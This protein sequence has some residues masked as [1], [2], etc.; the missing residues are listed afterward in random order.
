[1][2]LY[3]KIESDM[4]TALKEGD[5]LKLSV[6]R[7][8][9]AAARQVQINKNSKSVTESDMLQ[10]LQRHIKQH[11]ESI[12]QFGN[13]NRQDL[14]DKELAELKILE[15]YMPEQMSEEE[16]KSIIKAAIA[17]SGAKTKS[18][19]GKVMKLVMEKTKGAGDGKLISQL[20]ME[21]LQ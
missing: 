11:K 18:E 1:M 12:A 9:I 7:M 15:A 5:T 20:V 3:E 10:V 21:S 6:L 19:M 8:L 16:L 4:K 2:S 14:V 13:G 17:E